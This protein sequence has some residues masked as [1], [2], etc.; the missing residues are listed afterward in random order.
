MKIPFTKMQGTGN[1]FIL[2][3]EWSET[4][5]PDERKPAFVSFASKRHTGVGSDGVIFIQKSDEQDA[6]FVFFNPDGSRAEM[7]GNGIRCFAKLLHERGYV[8]ET[9]VSVETA[10]G[11]KNLKLTLYNDNVEQVRVDMGA[12][13]VLRGQAQVSGDPE[14][15]FVD[16]EVVVD[17]ESYR[18]TSVGVGNP[19]AVLFV[20]DV[21]SVDLDIVGARIR[22]Y[23]RVFPNGVNVHF[24]E[25]KD[26]NEFRV[27]TF[28]RG[29]EGETL[30]CGTGIC[31]AAVAAAL[32]E[33]ADPRK[34]LRF[35][36][37]GG[38]L[39]VEFELGEDGGITKIF[40]V[41]PAV[42]VFSGVLEYNPV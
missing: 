9:N 22:N 31:A 41:G 5:V 8:S 7:C 1:D 42:E 12:P 26:R 6:R 2:V 30:A 38:S 4:I 10:A 32:N 24:V 34:A 40:L 15:T 23:T 13:Q 36:A 19:H 16:Q 28:E 29:V 37:L 14:D 21:G 25:E 3:D 33:K 11:V 27:R 18:V 39:S 35:H 17:G 20:D